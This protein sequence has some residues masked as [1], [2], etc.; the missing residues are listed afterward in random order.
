MA[1]EPDIANPYLFNYVKGDE[2][3]AQEMVKKLVKEY[4]QN[5]PKGL[6]GNDD[7]GTMSAWL[8]YSMM[9]IYPISPGDPIYTITTPM[10]D[11]ITI[12]L[13]PKYYKKENIV[14]EKEIN[15]DGKINSIELN[16][17]TLNSFFISHEDFVNGKTLKVIQN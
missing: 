2:W 11:K 1:N 7:T 10:F 8:V 9:G 13:D 12:K 15:T 16:G 5:K 3:K 6:P 14:I 17:K 4:F